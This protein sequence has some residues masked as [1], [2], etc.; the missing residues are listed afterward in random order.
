[1]PRIKVIDPDV[2]KQAVDTFRDGQ[3]IDEVRSI[4]QV[5]RNKMIGLLKE[6]L[7]DEY[8]EIAR[9]VSINRWSSAAKKTNTGRSRGP[10]PEAQRQAISKAKMGVPLSDAHRESVSQGLRRHLEEFGFWHDK[11]KIAE[12]ARKG[13]ETKIQTGVY[14]KWGQLKL[15]K[16]RRHTDETRQKMSRARK[17]LYESGFE[18]PWKGQKHSPETLRALSERTSQMWAEGAFD[19][20]RGLWRS[21]LE[22]RVFDHVRE[23]FACSHSLRVGTRVFDIHVP[24][25]NLLIEINGDY[26]HFNPLLYAAEHYDDSRKISAQDIWTR[27]AEKLKAARAAGY[28]VLVLWQKDLIED[29]EGVINNAIDTFKRA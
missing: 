4:C 19:N 16:G 8:P 11:E 13:R 20:N 6:A 3:T 1:M 18:A 25:L 23:Q 29:F 27:D 2:L 7:G 15:F 22:E 24:A 5:G 12:I 17:A 9:Q 26:W 28:N 21:K 14:K 10:M